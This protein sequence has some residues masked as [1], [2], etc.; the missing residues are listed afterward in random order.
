MKQKEKLNKN[1]QSA[2]FIPIRKLAQLDKVDDILEH[3]NQ[4]QELIDN[5]MC[6]TGS[7]IEFDA[8][9]SQIN[10]DPSGGAMK[11]GVDK[12]LEKLKLIQIEIDRIRQWKHYLTHNNLDSILKVLKNLSSK[13]LFLSKNLKLAQKNAKN[14]SNRQIAL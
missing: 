14:L 3:K 8:S 2:I 12:Q 5:Q 9:A 11:L 13:Y 4:L 7:Q 1:L 6:Q 10:F